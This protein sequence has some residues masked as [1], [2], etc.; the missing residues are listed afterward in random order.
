MAY[1]YKDVRGKPSKVIFKRSIN[2]ATTRAL[3]V[4]GCAPGVYVHGYSAQRLCGLLVPGSTTYGV[5]VKGGRE[6]RTCGTRT[7]VR[8]WED[9]RT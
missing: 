6:L 9:V 4:H 7:C 2:R 1:F 8:T 5:L 3:G